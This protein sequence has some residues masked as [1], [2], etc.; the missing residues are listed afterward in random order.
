MDCN[1]FIPVRVS[2]KD[3]IIR[4]SGV[5]C[6]DDLYSIDECEIELLEEDIRVIFVDGISNIDFSNRVHNL[7]LKSM[8]LTL[9]VKDLRCRIGFNTLYNKIF[10]IWKSTHPLKPIDIENNY[11][12]VKFFTCSD[13][14]KVITDGPW[15]IF[16]HYLTIE[17]WS[18]YFSTSQSHPSRIMAWICLLGLWITCYKRTHLEAIVDGDALCSDTD[19]LRE[20]ATTYFSRLFV[21]G[22]CVSC[23]V[24]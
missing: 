1:T 6:D 5:A 20:E 17:P 15:I 23:I 12:L 11:F 16:G 8:D 10:N 3:T 13:Y 14:L 18:T 9:V 22:G 24:T 4:S 2:Y 7:A 21:L 19:I